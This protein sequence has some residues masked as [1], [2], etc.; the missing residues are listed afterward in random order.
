[1]NSIGYR[2]RLTPVGIFG[3][4][5]GIC[6]PIALGFLLGEYAERVSQ[7][8]GNSYMS[9]PAFPAGFVIALSVAASIGWILVLIGREHYPVDFETVEPRR[10]P[11][12]NS[13][14]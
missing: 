6:A 13:K 3:A 9:P 10:E 7:A 1:M 5:L 4:L 2:Q 11:Q 8:A 14:T 12:S